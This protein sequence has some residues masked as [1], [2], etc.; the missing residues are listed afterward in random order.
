VRVGEDAPG[1]LDFTERTQ[2]GRMTCGK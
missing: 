1:E 2:L